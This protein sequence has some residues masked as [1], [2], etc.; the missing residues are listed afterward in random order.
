MRAGARVLLLG[1]FAW[2]ACSSGET[3]VP[4]GGGAGTGGASAP[5]TCQQI[6]LC[7]AQTPCATDAC[8]QACAAK[9]APAAQT[10]FEALRACTARTCAVADVTCAC[11]EQC[12]ADGTCTDEVDQC[13][14][15]LAADDICDNLCH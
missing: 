6:R 7:V 2:G 3:A 15:G 1:L 4:D 5:M 8:V 13:L 10:A 9:G 12:I 11:N 14:A